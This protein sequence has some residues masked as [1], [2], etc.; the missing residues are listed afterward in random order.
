[1][2]SWDKLIAE[3]MAII[4]LIAQK[5]NVSQNYLTYQTDFLKAVTLGNMFLAEKALLDAKTRL[6]ELK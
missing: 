4:P 1:M 5:L 2:S 3:R 6:E